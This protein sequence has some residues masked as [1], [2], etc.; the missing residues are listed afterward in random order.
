MGQESEQLKRDIEE[1]RAGLGSD[2]DALSDKVSPKKVMGRRVDSTKASVSGLKDKV[3]GAAS[4]KLPGGGG[5]DSSGGIGHSAGD[6][7]S[8]VR[9]SAEGNPLAAGVVAFGLGFL[10]SSLLPSSDAETRAASTLVDKAQDN[11]G[12]LKEQLSAA[13]HDLTDSLKG[14]AQDAVAAVK[15]S[16]TDAA[17]NVKEH[18]GSA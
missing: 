18:A 5:S 16:A 17:S 1:T 6:A 9:A 13:G 15:S 3:L 7:A 14:P 12:P 11:A 10:L 8:S 4:D 2:V